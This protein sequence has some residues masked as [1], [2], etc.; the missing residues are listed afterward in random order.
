VA[1]AAFTVFLDDGRVCLSN[2]AVER[3]LR[4]IT[5][6]RK[7]WL[8]CGSDPVSSSN[9]HQSILAEMAEISA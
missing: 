8:F 2:N 6:G 5:P 3:G 1:W 9:R 4:G 7:S